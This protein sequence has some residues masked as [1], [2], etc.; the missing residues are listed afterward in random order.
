MMYELLDDFGRKTKFEG[1]L[2]VDDTTDTEDR[3]KPQWTDTEVYKTTG[4]KYVVWSD[5]QYRVRHLSRNCHKT[6]GYDIVPA[7]E[8]DSWACPACNPD[9]IL[10]GGYGQQ[11]RVTVDVCNTPTELIMR[12]SSINQQTGLRTHSNFSKAL[13]AQIS[14]VDDDVREAW[15]EQ[16]VS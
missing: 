9:K 16:V 4:G 15:M 5:V 2:L 1:F 11:D 7:E 3:R 8:S 14:E 13:L 6:Q 12:F 10:D